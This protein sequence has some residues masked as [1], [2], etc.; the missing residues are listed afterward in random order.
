MT[1]SVEQ[2]FALPVVDFLAFQG[3]SAPTMTT[4]AH[5]DVAAA[6]DQAC[7]THGFVCLRNSGLSKT[8]VEDMF[9]LSQR[10]FD[11]PAEEKSWFM[12]LDPTKNTGYGCFQ[13]EALNSLRRADLKETFNI[14]NPSQ[15]GYAGFQGTSQ[16]FQEVATEF[17]NQVTTLGRTFATCCAIAL[18]LELDYF[19]NTLTELDLSTL[20][21]LH[22]PPVSTIESSS[23]DDDP[24][25]ESIRVGE[26]TDFGLFTFLFVHEMADVSSQGLQVK[27]IDGA[28]LGLGSLVERESS[29][30][31]SGWKDVVFA[32]DFLKEIEGDNSATLLVNTGALMARWTNDTWRATAHRVVV[33]PEARCF[34][35]YSI[36]CFFDPDQKT[37][38]TVNPKF[39]RE[40]EEPKYPPISSMDYL[41][42]KLREAQGTKDIE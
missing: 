2:T 3:I 20:R 13:K 4:Q 40:G 34:H 6:L 17:W 7:R 31:T 38:C 33:K 5:Q 32:D 41:F 19:S 8:L 16:E 39:V 26:H 15:E 1:S 35:R 22:Y 42:M 18:G 29:I 12:Q 37:I 30:F 27:P 36:A 9:R 28:D 10:L 24:T 14:R 25:T 21:L 11:T 23:H